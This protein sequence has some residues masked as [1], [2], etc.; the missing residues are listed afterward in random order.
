MRTQYLSKVVSR[1]AIALLL[2]VGAFGPESVVAARA[3]GAADTAESSIHGDF[4]WDRWSAVV[5]RPD[6]KR[7]VNE[8]RS[9]SSYFIAREDLDLGRSTTSPS[10]PPSVRAWGEAEQWEDP[11][12]V[13]RQWTERLEPERWQ[14]L[15]DRH[16]A[17]PVEQGASNA[18]SVGIWRRVYGGIRTRTPSHFYAG[19]MTKS[20]LARDHVLGYDTIFAGS[21]SGGLWKLVGAGIFQIWVP[22]SD[23]LP[24]SPA[25]GDFAVNPTDSQNLIIAT[26][27]YGRYG[28]SG[29]YW[30]ANG[31]ESWTRANTP[32]PVSD[33]FMRVRIDRGNP[34]RVLACGSR[35]V[36]RSTDFGRNWNRVWNGQC[37]DLIQDQAY[38][39]FWFVARFGGAIFESSDGGVSFG[40]TPIANAFGATAR[41]VSLASPISSGNIL[42]ALATSQ[43][44]PGG[45]GVGLN[46]VWRST[47]YGR[48]WTNINPTDL[49]GWGQAYHTRAIE[50]HPYNPN[51]VVIGLG[52]NQFTTNAMAAS[53]TA[54]PTWRIFDGGHVDFTSFRFFADSPSSTDT[55]IGITNDGGY[56]I[57]NWSEFSTAADGR[58]NNF[59]LHTTQAMG[60]AAIAASPASDSVVWHALQDNGVVK[61][62]HVSAVQHDLITGGDG[63]QVSL[64]PDD[65]NHVAFS[66]GVDYVRALTLDGGSSHSLVDCGLAVPWAPTAAINPVAGLA[67]S[68]PRLYTFTG[69]QAP[70]VRAQVWRR[71][72]N[73]N[74]A[75]T[76]SPLIGGA[77]PLPANFNP[78]L[79]EIANTS[80]ALVIYLTGWGDR[81][82][83][84][85]DSSIH[86]S[87]PNMSW[88]ERTPAPPSGASGNDAVVYAD[89]FRGNTAYYVSAISRPSRVLRSTNRG[90]T[91]TDVT[92]NLATVVPDAHYWVVAAHPTRANELY[93]GTSVGVY[94]TDDGGV[95]WYRY[96][97]GMPA[98]TDA[99]SMAVNGAASPPELLVSTYGHGLWKRTMDSPEILFRHGFEP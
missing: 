93:L 90:V 31:G 77:T 26:G 32:N 33:S 82:V 63:G 27:D 92:G 71:P 24:G 40:A 21:S 23:N 91:W 97:H 56:F 13:K 62:R 99:I 52:Q 6:P 19:R 4:D 94:R 46:G 8:G 14:S 3:P 9:K 47:D 44:E 36:Y 95:N 81:R 29:I 84:V 25:V 98:V 35:G 28:G 41:E 80:T 20:Q 68:S 42:F 88:A 57:W 65:V 12:K 87:P 17:A 78:R 7:S 30:S 83:F 72:L 2:F 89:R 75:T 15:I 1:V 85:I 45:L 86:G 96:G 55:R 10:T 61:I 22:L 51:I 54:S 43:S 74:C 53:P 67:A 38:P 58:L 37:T 69:P 34:Q 60:L 39:S 49:I 64:S 48:T 73:I 50:V 59:G 76:W 16:L 70:S 18:K 5:R 11:V 79:L 66:V